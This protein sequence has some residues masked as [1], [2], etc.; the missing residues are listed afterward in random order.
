[1][2]TYFSLSNFS[3]ILRPTV[4]ARQWS[5]LHCFKCIGALVDWSRLHKA[6]S[7][8]VCFL[9]AHFLETKWFTCQLR[10]RFKKSIKLQ[11]SSEQG[12]G[13]GSENY[14]LCLN[15]IFYFLNMTFKH[16][17]YINMVKFYFCFLFK[18]LF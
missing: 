2:W 17:L 11:T 3:A 9:L 10:E 18:G 1:M 8:S 4:I 5:S 7:I 13:G 15:P 6:F 12:G 14:P 16:K